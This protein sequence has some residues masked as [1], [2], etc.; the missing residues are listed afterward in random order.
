MEAG[1]P[2]VEWSEFWRVSHT[3]CEGRCAALRAT[4]PDSGRSPAEALEAA[5]RAKVA[6][7]LPAFERAAILLQRWSE[8]ARR[9]F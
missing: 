7:K 6:E 2:W 9:L 8:K 3:R 4:G 1:D 5:V